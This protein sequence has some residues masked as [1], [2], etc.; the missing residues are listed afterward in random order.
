MQS[1]MEPERPP[2]VDWSKPIE[3]H[4]KD[5]GVHQVVLIGFD[6]K[7]LAVVRKVNYEQYTAF[8]LDGSLKG[9]STYRFIRNKVGV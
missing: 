8:R 5:H 7:D 9:G 2:T 1:M 4:E 3:L 6:G